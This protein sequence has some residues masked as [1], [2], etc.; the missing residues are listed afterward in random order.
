MRKIFALLSLLVIASMAL[1]ACGGAATT[2]APAASDG[3][4][5]PATEASTGE[6]AA[7]FT[8]ADPTTFVVAES[9][10]GIDTLDPALAYDTASGEVIQNVYETLVFYDGEATDKFV[11]MLAESWEVSADGSVYTFKIRADVKFHNGDVMTPSDVAYSFQRGVLQGGYSSP[12]WLL[13]EP[14]F[15]VGVDDISLL[16][17]EGASADDREA[18]SANDPA[19]LVAACE[20][21]K[22]AVVAD[23]AAGTVTMT[24]K[25]PWGPFLATIAQTWGSVMDQKWVVENGG[26]DGSCD[27][28]QNYY[29]MASADDPFSGIVNGTGPFT[30]EKFAN[31][32]EIIMARN[33]SYWGEPAKLERVILKQ[34]P[35]WGTRFA[36]MQ[37]G[38]ADVATVPPANRSQ[39]DELV[40]QFATYDEAANTYGPLQP[41]CDYDGSAL[42]AAKFTACAAG[43]A[44][45][46]GL[47]N[48]RIGR[49]VTSMDVLLFN[50]NIATSE[51]SPNPY[52]G[53]GALDGNGIPADFFGDVHIRKAFA[54]CFDFDTLINDVYSGEAIQSLQLTLPG[55]PGFFLDTPHYTFDPAQCEAEFKLADV[56]KDG[57]AA[58]DDPEGDVWTN[59]FRVQMSYNQGNATRQ[60]I[61]EILA[62]NLSAVNE[63]FQVETLGLPWP[64]YLRAQRAAQLPL[65]TA[66]WQ[67]DI[68]DPHNWYQ[69]YTTGTYGG[70]AQLPQE[71]K[72]QFKAIL[73]AGVSELDPA[74]RA[75]I[76]KE[77]NQLYYDLVAGVPLD[78]VTSHGFSQRWVEGI[79]YNPIFPGIYYYTISKQ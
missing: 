44:N 2:A 4:E 22:A 21:T 15:G 62:G 73:D 66:G 72:D 45:T 20:T 64:A 79:V 19:V 77:A 43:E 17:D 68:H 36:M 65:M 35:E 48:L 61:T 51:D 58:G 30:L 10:V 29:G 63:L 42:G 38:D 6:A 8:S 52:L 70:R 25:Q 69:P 37:A 50:W 5:A 12:Q 67:E 71:V 14:F 57:I 49:P 60:T 39:M 1:T 27:T 23:D 28:W 78:V 75:E 76:Y 59:G 13:A 55:M 34:V 16:V 53:S 56:D 46:D 40:G 47:F 24:L 54:Y 33:E 9:E 74:K 31:G 3:A 11:P 32:E 41:V 26:W 7:T 18:L